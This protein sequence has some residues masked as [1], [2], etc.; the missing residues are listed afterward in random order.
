MAA[1]ATVR[2]RCP[3]IRPSPSAP[4]S[5][6]RR[7][8][9]TSTDVLRYHLAL[10]AGAEPTDPAE[11]HYVLEDR[12]RVLP[13]FGV[14]APGFRTFEPPAVR[15]PGIDVDLSKVLHGTQSITVTGPIPPEGEAVA[16]SRIADVWDKGKAAVIVRETVVTSDRGRSTVDGQLRHLRPR[17]GRVRRRSRAVDGRR[18]TRARAGPVA[19]GA[20]ATPSKRCCIGCAATATHCTPTRSSPRRP[21]SSG[22]SCTGCAPTGWSASPLWTQCWTAT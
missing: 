13:T 22:R 20:R 3:S 11:L 5:V 19:R 10:G 1:R 7:F 2:S 12:L 21:G 9:W 16:R 17:R 18:G 6:R 15:F 8:S 14:V 4:T